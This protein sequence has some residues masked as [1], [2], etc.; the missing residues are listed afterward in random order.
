MAD[1][2]AARKE[3]DR[4]LRRAQA[5]RGQGEGRREGRRGQGEAAPPLIAGTSARTRRTPVTPRPP[6]PEYGP[7][8]VGGTNRPGSR[9]NRDD[10]AGT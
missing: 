1:A 6:W 7:A 10:E 8:A 9:R 2:D 3:A 5:R 4:V